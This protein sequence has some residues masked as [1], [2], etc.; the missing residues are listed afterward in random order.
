MDFT[1]VLRQ[2]HIPVLQ[3][4]QE[5][6]LTSNANDSEVTGNFAERRVLKLV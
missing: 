3:L 4:F 2:S 6:M 5:K 1:L